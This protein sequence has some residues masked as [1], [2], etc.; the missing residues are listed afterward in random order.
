M[1]PPGKR[2][3]VWRGYPHCRPRP[4]QSLPGTFSQS[5]LAV[6]DPPLNP[7]PVTEIAAHLAERLERVGC[8]YALGGAVALS[9]WTE[10]RGTVDVDVSLFLPIDDLT[11]TIEVFH[12]IGVEFTEQSSRES[13][14]TH[15]FCRVEFLER[16]L[17]VFLP[18]ADIYQAAKSR[19]Q[20]MPIG[21]RQVYVWDAESLCVFKMIFFRRKDLADVESILRSQ[22]KL[23]KAWIE[24]QL[25]AMYGAA[26]PRLARWKE[27]VADCHSS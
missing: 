5:K 17:D 27:I 2:V 6:P 11:Q 15:G 7:Q 16:R 12:K 18:I 22:P 23:E 8:D 25:R 10:P 14:A 21:G 24:D 4:G 13:L 20:Q 19:R 9:C 3:V 1:Q 26:D